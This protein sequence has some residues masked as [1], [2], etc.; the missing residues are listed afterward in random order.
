MEGSEILKDRIELLGRLNLNGKC[1]AEVGVCSGSYSVEIRRQ[2]PSKLILVDPWALN[3]KSMKGPGEVAGGMG[4]N[5]YLAVRLRFAG[6]P[7]VMVIRGTSLSASL[8]IPERT[9][10]FVYIDA[11]HDFTSVYTDLLLWYPKLMTGG[12]LAGHDLDNPLYRIRDAVDTFL[13]MTGERLRFTTS[14]V[15]NKQRDWISNSFAIRK[16][17]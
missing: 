15:F 16:S 14:E 1:C 13:K 2:N 7:S 6:D 3:G 5:G 17:R 4:D 11:N 12:W 8:S 10:D 9:L